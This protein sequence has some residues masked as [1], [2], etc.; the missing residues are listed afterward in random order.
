MNT[1]YASGIFPY[2][3]QNV[4]WRTFKMRLSNVV[5]PLIL[6]VTARMVVK[7]ILDIILHQQQENT[8]TTNNKNNS[9]NN[10][11][12]NSNK[13]RPGP[14]ASTH[15]RAGHFSWPILYGLADSRADDNNDNNSNNNNNNKKRKN[16]RT[17]T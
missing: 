17:T 1:N 8:N 5:F 12:N 11:N 2:Y 10:K 14:C 3:P 9:N 16:V 7:V 6:I 15:L 4:A 13:V